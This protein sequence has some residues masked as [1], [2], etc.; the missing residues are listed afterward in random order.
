MIFNVCVHQ[1][2][3]TNR[4]CH[5]AKFDKVHIK[6]HCSIATIDQSDFFPGFPYRSKGKTKSESFESYKPEYHADLSKKKVQFAKSY[7]LDTDEQA[8]FFLEAEQSQ[9][10]NDFFKAQPSLRKTDTICGMHRHTYLRFTEVL[11]SIS[12]GGQSNSE[13]S[14]SFSNLLVEVKN[15]HMKL[16][17][18]FLE[19]YLPII[20]LQIMERLYTLTLIGF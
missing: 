15:S 7:P 18:K 8:S 14:E 4:V 13:P 12:R 2:C 9:P 5:C 17:E 1:S 3:P 20:P 11:S 19:V 10:L 6:S 16:I